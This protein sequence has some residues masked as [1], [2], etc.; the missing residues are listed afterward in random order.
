MR[1]IINLIISKPN[2]VKTIINNKRKM[3]W[4]CCCDTAATDRATPRPR[5]PRY[6]RLI[7]VNELSLSSAGGRSEGARPDPGGYSPPSVP[8]SASGVPTIKDFVLLKT[9]GKGTFG[10]VGRVG[11]ARGCLVP[12]FATCEHLCDI[13]ASLLV[14]CSSDIVP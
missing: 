3:S 1:E 11:I 10:K 9:L 6:D 14:S 5:D 13:W 12:C 7:P 8:A 2:Y 4:C